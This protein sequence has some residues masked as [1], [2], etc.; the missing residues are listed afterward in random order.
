MNFGLA[1]PLI[2][3]IGYD[4]LYLVFIQL[5]KIMKRYLL[6]QIFVARRESGFEVPL[7]F[8]AELRNS[9]ELLVRPP[10]NVQKFRKSRMAVLKILK[11]KKVLIRKCD[12]LYVDEVGRVLIFTMRHYKDGWRFGKGKFVCQMS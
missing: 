2:L 12:R 4:K 11:T 6:T 8:I 9:S 5:N 3:V 1:R 10:S 7:G